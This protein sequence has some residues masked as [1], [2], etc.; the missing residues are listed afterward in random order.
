M[1]LRI[2]LAGASE[3]LQAEAPGAPAGE[4]AEAAKRPPAVGEL[5]RPEPGRKT[6]L[7]IKCDFPIATYGRL[8]PC[9][10]T[11]CY[12]C[13]HDIGITCYL[14]FNQVLEIE[15]VTKAEEVHVCGVCL[16]SFGGRAE[17][18]E[19]VQEVHVGNEIVLA[20]R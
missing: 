2:R 5:L 8:L 12:Q 13:A 7:C 15:R 1:A 3:P 20:G 4:A 18:A 16:A 10:H 6:H 9:R 14:C 17:L 19:H 11:F